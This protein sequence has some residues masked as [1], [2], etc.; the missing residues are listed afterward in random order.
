MYEVLRIS[1][2]MSF[3]LNILIV[4]WKNNSEYLKLAIV[5]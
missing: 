5:G 3:G 2:E 4:S 1:K